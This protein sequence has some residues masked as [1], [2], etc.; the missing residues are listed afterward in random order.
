MLRMPA[1]LSLS[2][3]LALALL[4]SC[5]KDE[6]KKADPAGSGTTAEK[7][8]EIGKTMG[9]GGQPMQQPT[10]QAAADLDMIPVDSEVV[11]GLNFAQLQQSAIW[12]KSIMPRLAKGDFL[13]KLGELK[14][15]CGFDPMVAI[16]TVSLGLKNLADDK[17][18]G[19]IVVH[20]LDKDKTLACL[21]NPKTREDMKDVDVSKDGDLTLLKDKKDGDTMAVKFVDDTTLVAVVGGKATKDGVQ[22]IIG[23]KSTL[24]T[25]PAFVDMYG[26]INA[27]DS[28]WALVNGNMKGVDKLSTLLGLKPK[29][30]FGSVNVTDGLTADLRMRVDTPDQAAQTAAGLSQQAAMAKQF[31]DNVAV[32]SDGSDVKLTLAISNAKLMALQSQMKGGGGGLGGMGGM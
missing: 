14:S 25:S 2:L 12:Q 29:A 24:R 4:S 20:G 7:G 15:R 32:T 23:G 31:V 8:G 13:A 28:I 22:S 30:L 9:G 6:E 5:K 19:V 18:E 1:V 27:Q 10:G 17:P 21:D 3:A 16:K 11:A 26:K